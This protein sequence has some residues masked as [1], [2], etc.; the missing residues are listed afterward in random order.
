[1]GPRAGLRDAV[2]IVNCGAVANAAVLIKRA[3][4]RSF[5]DKFGLPTRFGRC[6]A[7]PA[8]ELLFVACVTV[9][10]MPDCSS[11]IVFTC[12]PPSSTF[13]KPCAANPCPAPIGR[14]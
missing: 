10:G 8:K 6:N 9:T 7:N 4:E 14:S 12:Q 5:G 2:P 1:A 11:S 3:G 13:A